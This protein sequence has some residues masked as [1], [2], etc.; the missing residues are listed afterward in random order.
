[1]EEQ[2]NTQANVVTEMPKDSAS[3]NTS[4]L[5][6][7]QPEEDSR[8]KKKFFFWFIIILALFALI[9]SILA[10]GKSND[11]ETR[12][13]VDEPKD[14]IVEE[15]IV[16]DEVKIIE[17]ENKLVYNPV[18]PPAPLTPEPEEIS[19]EDLT[20]DD[21]IEANI[22]MAALNPEDI[23][24]DVVA[25][26]LILWEDLQALLEDIED[27]PVATTTP[28]TTPRRG[29]G[30]G[31]GGGSVSLSDE[32]NLDLFKVDVIDV[33]PLAGLQV[34]SFDEQGATLISDDYFCSDI[35]FSS[36]PCVNKN[37]DLL[38][39]FL[40]PID[41]NISYIKVEIDRLSL[42]PVEFIWENEEILQL[43][44]ENILAGDVI[45]VTVVAEDGVTTNLY[46]L[47][48]EGNV[49]DDASL[50]LF[51][52]DFIDVLPLVGL[53]VSDFSEEG[54]NLILSDYQCENPNFSNVRC[55]SEKD[56]L[57]GIFIEP[58]D[59]D[60]SYIK[61]EI[62]RL[63][64]MP[65]ELVWENE[66]ILKLHTE[67]ILLGDVIRVTVVSEDG[68]TTNLYKVNITDKASIDTSLNKF[69]IDKYDILSLENLEIK[70]K[71][72]AGAVLYIDDVE[73]CPDWSD[74]ICNT[75]TLKSL[76]VSATQPDV[77]YIGVSLLRDGVLK[78][79][80]NDEINL[81]AQEKFLINDV[82]SVRVV[83][84]NAWHETMYKV[85]IKAASTE[86]EEVVITP[87]ELKLVKI[88]PRL[89]GGGGSAPA[90]I[91]KEPINIEP[92][93]IIPVEKIKKVQE[94]PII[95]VKEVTSID[96]V[97]EVKKTEP[98]IIE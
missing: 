32:A 81:L 76:I 94:K 30:G 93:Q 26:C 66:E 47:N 18:L 34:E 59:P 68:K 78:L 5:K 52:I 75:S 2:K 43:Q 19:V 89:V 65:V 23:T 35:E 73:D 14:S 96:P 10:F 27:E 98:A 87:S 13:V 62:K 9:Q 15:I 64:L 24:D 46:K 88:K 29:G 44:T 41:E 61:V 85:T 84:K 79:W 54:A 58:L 42:M 91:E 4:P 86:V 72:S 74:H 22:T 11:E 82:V 20:I 39:L 31:G 60:F 56:N 55:I 8:K 1:M 6:N 28:T 17:E 80:E 83:S 95:E 45:M 67:D 70:D 21:C 3:V 40:A 33:L 12:Q 57:T 16:D 25:Q 49:V 48:I 71:A 53:K 50:S 90:K 77:S 38:G 7:E 37:Q 36:T 51:N 97:I 92:I 63:S 69:V